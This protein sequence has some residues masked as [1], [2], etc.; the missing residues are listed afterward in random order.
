MVSAT[1]FVGIDIRGGSL[2]RHQRRIGE[3]RIEQRLEAGFARDLRLGPPLL[4]VGRVEVF[5]FDFVAAP[6]DRGQQRRR[7]LALL[8]RCS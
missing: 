7:H 1:P 4:L 8:A 2:F 3:Q 6:H 5:E